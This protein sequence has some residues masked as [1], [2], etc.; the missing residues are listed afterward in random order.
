MN[1]L[2]ELSELSYSQRVLLYNQDIF[3]IGFTSV[4]EEH[5]C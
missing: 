5:V 2:D 3:S 4:L 1:Y